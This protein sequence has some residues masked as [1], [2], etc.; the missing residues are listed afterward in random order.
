MLNYFKKRKNL[1]IYYYY[2]LDIIILYI[3]FSL[4]E[5]YIF[6]HSKYSFWYVEML[7]S[8]DIYKVKLNFF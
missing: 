4:G 5:L 6:I 2:F 7:S 3:F 1:C 8:P